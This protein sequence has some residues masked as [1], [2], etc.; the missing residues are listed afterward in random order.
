VKQPQQVSKKKPHPCHDRTPDYLEDDWFVI[1]EPI[2]EHYDQPHGEEKVM[3][4]SVTV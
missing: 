1:A 2:E 3:A 4:F